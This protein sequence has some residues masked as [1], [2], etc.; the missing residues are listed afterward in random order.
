MK[1]VDFL[2]QVLNLHHGAG[3]SE[4]FGAA[5]NRS[6]SV[7]SKGVAVEFACVVKNG[8]DIRALSSGISKMCLAER[9]DLKK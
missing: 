1:K 4:T 6:K 7:S 5:R 2:N 9:N 8:F 3:G